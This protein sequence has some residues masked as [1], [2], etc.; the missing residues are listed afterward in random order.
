MVCTPLRG[1]RRSRSRVAA[2][3]ALLLC[4]ASTAPRVA[5]A[6][7]AAADAD[8]PLAPVPA[9]VLRVG[10][11]GAAPFV[12]PLDPSSP[13]PRG[14]SIDVWREVAARNHWAYEYRRVPTTERLLALVVSGEIDV[15]VGPT[16]ITADRSRRVAFS[17][18]Y[19]D[20]SLAILGRAER[21]YTD[22]LRPFLS[23]AFAIGVGS[24]LLVLLTVGALVWLAERRRNAQQ[25][26][27]APAAGI[28][29]GVWLALVTMT[30]VGYGDRAPV[31]PLGRVI[32]GV[33]MF[34]ALVISSSLTASLTTALTLSQ[35][36]PAT[37]L[38]L[39]DLR[40]RRVGAV[41]ETT[42]ARFV[43]R[44]GGTSVAFPT[45]DAAARALLRREVSAVVFDRPALRYYVNERPA[46]P[47]Q[48]SEASY[49]PQGY[50]LSVRHGSPLR[51]PIDVA[52]LSLRQDG[53]VAAIAS[54]W[55]GE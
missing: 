11:A 16:S 25:F 52:L 13:D 35:L 5:G 31:T 2:A 7:D 46:E 26:P 14:L 30:T 28:A 55:L 33:W 37:A 10:V 42:S 3:V 44:H 22:R 12:L 41:A 53:S 4:V 32:M 40:G 51:V 43:A 9:R 36:D 8:A 29:N 19:Q 27:P 48:I 6:Q 49:E 38:T 20:A 39:S 15:G 50:G 34:A 1:F 17:Q 45:L 21:R 54:R 23:R 47:L 18:P 24:L